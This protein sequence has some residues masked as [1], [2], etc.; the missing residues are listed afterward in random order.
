MDRV[1]YMRS[2]NELDTLEALERTP[3]KHG[4]TWGRWTLSGN[5]DHWSL[6]L[7]S[8][9]VSLNG[10]TS[11]AEMNDWIFQLVNKLW[12]ATDDLGNLVLAF[13]DIFS[14]QATLCGMGQ[15]KRLQL[16]YVNGVLGKPLG[17]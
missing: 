15:D 4:D 6:D 3:P 9:S 7:Q 1:Q 16:D 14:P 11:N 10:I 8:Y 2:N 17:I 5:G 12:V 13:Q